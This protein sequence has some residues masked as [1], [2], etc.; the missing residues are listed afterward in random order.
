MV[1]LWAMRGRSQPSAPTPVVSAEPLVAEPR[2]DPA[3]LDAEFE[4]MALRRK[5][6][7]EAATLADVED[8]AR[9]ALL[10]AMERKLPQTVAEATVSVVTLAAEDLKG[11]IIGRDGRNKK[12]FEQTTGVDLIVDESPDS[13]TLSSFDPVR[14]EVARLALLDLLKDGKIHP[15]RIEEAHAAALAAVEVS[16]QQGADRAMAEAKVSG[17][18]KAVRVALGQLAYRTSVGQNL[19]DHSIE[20]AVLAGAVAAEIG[21]DE[22]EARR[23]GL[24][25]DIGKGLDSEWEGPHALAGMRFLQRHGEA[26]AVLH[27]VGAH[28]RDI[29][30]ATA[31]ALAVIVGD[32]LSAARPGARREPLQ[33][34]VDRLR[35]L[36]EFV[37]AFEGVE[38]VY[39]VQ[40]GREVR[41]IVR[42]QDVD[43]LAAERLANAIARGIEASLEYPGQ[44]AV[45]VVREWRV[46]VVAQ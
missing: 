38:Q 3:T 6:A 11:R 42:P 7:I 5:K 15:T 40:G 18:A 24:L 25:H 2:P 30:P 22:A 12:V 34:H 37:R 9:K 33:S 45:T 41:V 39:A 35:D 19:L 46:Q 23:A 27:A 31:E 20:T 29:E 4:E 8:R 36:E 10:A 43:D 14:R 17:L 16:C 32:G 13:V 1:V 44:I 26:E 21:A 28:H